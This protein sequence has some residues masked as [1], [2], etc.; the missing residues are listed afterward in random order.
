[1]N[2]NQWMNDPALAN[3]DKSKLMFLGNLISQG[4]SL[5]Q[6]EMLPFL[7]SFVKQSKGSNISF[8]KDEIQLIISVSKNYATPEELEKLE[9]LSPFFHFQ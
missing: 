7:L 1:M 3:I 6:K 4:S 9:K 2:N 8:T 5:N